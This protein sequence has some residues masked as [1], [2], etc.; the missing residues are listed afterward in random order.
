MT[1][2]NAEIEKLLIRLHAIDEKA[3][4]SGEISSDAMFGLAKMLSLSNEVAIPKIDFLE[5][6]NEYE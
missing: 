4:S 6:A 5:A 1:G 3:V 2:E